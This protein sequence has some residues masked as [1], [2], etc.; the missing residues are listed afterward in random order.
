MKPEK[1]KHLLSQ[2]GTT[3]R[4]FLAPEDAKS[5]AKRVKNGG[6]K[7]RMF[8][9][10]WIEFTDKRKAKLVAETLNCQRIGGAKKSFWYDDLWNLKYLPRFKWDDLT[11]QINAERQ[12]RQ[13]R[14]DASLE[15]SKREQRAYLESTRRAKMVKK[16]ESVRAQRGEEDDRVRRQ[17]RQ[18]EAKDSKDSGTK[19]AQVLGKLF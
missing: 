19:I 10:G 17:F 8:T 16:M 18:R 4:I 6:N 2:Y 11:A 9:E 3:G 14:L 12:S 1:V 7:R 15:Q 13:A 5:H